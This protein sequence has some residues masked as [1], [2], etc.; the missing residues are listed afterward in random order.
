MR[1]L[2]RVF[3]LVAMT[4][5]AFAQ[6]TLTQ[7]NTPAIGQSSNSYSA[8][9][10]TFDPSATGGNQNWNVTS[11]SYSDDG[12]DATYV[13]PGSTPY[14]AEYPTANLATVQGVDPDLSYTFFRL[15]SNGL[16]LL[17]I[18]S[19]TG[20]QEF[21]LA[22]D[23]E[24]LI[25]PFPMTMGTGWSSVY[26]ITLEPVPGFSVATVDSSRI[27]VQAWGTMTTP[28][29]T[30]SCLKALDH[31]YNTSYLNG[32]QQG[33]TTEMWSYV[34]FTSN[35]SRTVDFDNQDATGPDFT[36]GELSYSAE[37]T[38]DTPA[39]RGPVSESFKLSQNYPNP[40]N[41]S[42]TLPIELAKSGK[43]EVTIYN[44][45]G[46][47]VSHMEQDLTAGQH[48]LPI[49]GSAWSSGSY[50]AKVMAGNEVQSTRMV[51]VK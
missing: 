35:P 8:S 32:Q 14:A 30:E 49:D 1:M 9:A 37:G 38:T 23:N 25:I 47:V 29:W 19:V 44:E 28:M 31:S 24:V 12:F 20:G 2:L 50:F 22:P 5:T 13:A 16:Y 40:F 18:V 17:G 15:A 11:Y 34:W 48:S 39:P 26:R 10:V 21:V 33:P 45:V 51:L 36:D 43:V 27:E 7:A 41:P 42:T 4:L 3:G 46:Q 6:I